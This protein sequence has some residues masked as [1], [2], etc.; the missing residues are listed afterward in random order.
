MINYHKN[1]FSIYYA[2]SSVLF[3]LWSHL[4][5]VNELKPSSAEDKL[6]LVLL[7]NH[8]SKK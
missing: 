3:G 7:Q 4:G 6:A 8:Q 2:Q 5:S 1:L